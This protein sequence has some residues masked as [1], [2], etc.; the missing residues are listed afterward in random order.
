MAS[1]CEC[2]C[3]CGVSKIMLQC[4]VCHY[5][6][7]DTNCF[8]NEVIKTLNQD[9]KRTV[10]NIYHCHDCNDAIKAANHKEKLRRYNASKKYAEALAEHNTRWGKQAHLVKFWGK[11]EDFLDK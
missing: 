7:T 5:S 10:M 4:N 8:V 1:K 9:G 2:R 11:L 6:S 3:H